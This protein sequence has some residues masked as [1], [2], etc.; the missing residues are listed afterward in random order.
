M[1]S[2]FIELGMMTAL[3]VALASGCAPAV[4]KPAEKPA[5]RGPVAVSAPASSDA[6]YAP[7]WIN[8]D[9]RP[10]GEVQAIGSTVVGLVVDDG[11]LL[12]IGIDPATGRELWH[13]PATPGTVTIGVSVQLAKIGEDKVAYL[14]P[15]R[16]GAPLT[17]LV[18]ADAR[19][20][21]DLAV[22]P[23][24]WFTTHPF[25]CKNDQD[26][27]TLAYEDSGGRVHEF[28][29]EAT[30][31]KYLAESQG[32]PSGT[33]RLEASG[34]VDLGDRPGNTLGLLRDG[35]L[36]WNIPASSAFPPG[37]SSDNGWA[38]HRFADQHIVA[39]SLNGAPLATI[40]SYV[41]DL[42]QGSAMAGIAEETGEVRWRD[43]GSSFL[44]NIGNADYPV[45]CRR[46]GRAMREPGH[47]GSFDGLDVTVE[48]FDPATGATTWSVPVGPAANLVDSVRSVPIAGPTQ[49]V[50]NPPTGP[51]VLDYT[52]G[53]VTPAR[54]GATFWCMT[55]VWYELAD[56]Y[57]LPDGKR[58]F[59]RPG[60][61]LGAICDALGNRSDALPSLEATLAVGAHVGSHIVVATPSGYIGF[62]V[63]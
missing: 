7:A 16:K 46:R 3:A 62:Q 36:Q 26:A 58:H 39:G 53:N 19:S 47:P 48:G 18:V 60:G 37:F 51:I 22:S 40:P 14:R 33:R 61:A 11:R 24:E 35:K 1:V 54:A 32:L 20:G 42:E 44:C 15:L 28:R 29:L 5:P 13:Q 49:A 25:A 34:L 50:V 21:R 41:Q 2:R 57:T 10:I 56:G 9:R 59:D 8:T 12:A 31:G 63:R 6:R 23:P 55:G 4:E 30:S 27:C 45:R 52:T 17:Q 38:W 43:P